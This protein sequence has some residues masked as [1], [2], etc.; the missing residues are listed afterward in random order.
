MVSR[1]QPCG[2]HI[3]HDPGCF[4]SYTE[5]L[6]LWNSSIVLPLDVATHHDSVFYSDVNCIRFYPVT[7]GRHLVTEKIFTYRAVSRSILSMLLSPWITP[8]HFLQVLIYEM[9]GSLNMRSVIENTDPKTSV[10]FVVLIR[11][12]FHTLFHRCNA[13]IDFV[14]LANLLCFNLWTLKNGLI[15]VSIVTAGLLALFHLGL[16]SHPCWRELLFLIRRFSSHV[17]KEKG[18]GNNYLF[19]C[20][21]ICYFSIYLYSIL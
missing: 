18:V 9:G 5:K 6:C 2:M 19:L 10:S 13:S 20:A 3:F 7:K 8:Y 16:V 4:W 11:S 14:P 17:S 15:F 1:R 21:L 12:I